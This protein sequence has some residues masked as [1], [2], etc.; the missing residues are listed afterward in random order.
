MQESALS[1]GVGAARTASRAFSTFAKFPPKPTGIP[2]P[3]KPPVVPARPPIVEPP[4]VPVPKTK[5]PVVKPRF[6][7]ATEPAPAIPKA[8]AP[9]GVTGGGGMQRWRRFPMGGNTAVPFSNPAMVLGGHQ[10]RH[11]STGTIANWWQ[12]LVGG[13]GKAASV[14]VPTVA[15][16]GNTLFNIIPRGHALPALKLRSK[17]PT[18]SSLEGGKNYAAPLAEFGWPAEQKRHGVF[19]VTLGMEGDMKGKGKAEHV[20]MEVS[21]PFETETEGEGRPTKKHWL[22]GKTP[23]RKG[24]TEEEW[25]A[26]VAAHEQTEGGEH[27]CSFPGIRLSRLDA[28]IYEESPSDGGEP[29][30]RGVVTSSIAGRAAGETYR[31]CLKGQQLQVTA[32]QFERSVVGF[33]ENL[34]QEGIV[35]ADARL[36]G[37]SI[38]DYGF[39]KVADFSNVVVDPRPASEGGLVKPGLTQSGEVDRRVVSL[40][41]RKMLLSTAESMRRLTSGMEGAGDYLMKCEAELANGSFVW[42]AHKK[43]A[44]QVRGFN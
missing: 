3:A 25:R 36:S 38:A 15:Q 33:Y 44:N 39:L 6:S 24:Q 42:G 27:I 5:P 16:P 43:D 8:S 18:Y 7:A 32:E 22:D 13:G 21:Q 35:L 20:D 23:V 30:R 11:Y 17:I 29:Q 10:A 19:S 26:S 2:V 28:F 14:E 34:L 40:R 9:F 12:S 1:R 37:L 4:V 31:S 41:L